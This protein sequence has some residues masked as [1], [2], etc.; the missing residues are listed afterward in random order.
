MQNKHFFSEVSCLSWLTWGKR[1][2]LWS[3]GAEPKVLYDS[4]LESRMLSLSVCETYPA[5]A[6][7][8]KAKEYCDFLKKYFY[9][10]KDDFV[11]NIPPQRLSDSLAS[12]DI[13]GVEIRD[14]DKVLVGCIFDIYAGNFEGDTMGLVT[15]MCV[16]PSWRKKGLGTDL[17]YAL[18]YYCRPRRIHWWRNDGFLKS[19]LPPVYTD[20][21]MTRARRVHEC[22][23]DRNKCS[24]NLQRVEMRR[25][26]QRFIEVWKQGAPNGLVLDD[27]VKKSRWIECWELDNTL[28]LLLQPTFETK[29][30]TNKSIYEI[31][32]WIFIKDVNG[33]EAELLEGA[34]DHLPYDSFE[35]PQS[36]PHK[37][38]LWI[39]GGTST[40]LCI[41]L[42]PGSVPK[43]ILPLLT[44]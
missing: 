33:E 29:K 13:V 43:P 19:P 38:E 31:I 8:T 41:G 30:S 3:D 23:N 11:L 10:E 36:M 32:A 22:I 6:V 4:P 37:K 15:W 7:P 39:H 42:D 1:R 27:T 5:K 28:V 2:F 17:L 34:I 26:K 16:A 35:A 14:K 25:W 18:Y 40:W 20:Y 44:V 9:N 21:K 12:E 24:I